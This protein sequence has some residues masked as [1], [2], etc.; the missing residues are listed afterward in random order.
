MTK[1]GFACS[2]PKEIAPLYVVEK[3]DK[4]GKR[5]D[6]DD[7]DAPKEDAEEEFHDVDSP[8]SAKEG[9]DGKKAV[10]RGPRSQL[11]RLEADGSEHVSGK[12]SCVLSAGGGIE[13]VKG[14][15][16]GTQVDFQQFVLKLMEDP[17]TSPRPLWSKETKQVAL[18]VN[19]LPYATEGRVANSKG[20]NMQWNLLGQLRGHVGNLKRKK[21]PETNDWEDAPLEEQNQ[22][23]LKLAGSYGW[24]GFA[25][26]R[27]MIYPKLNVAFIMMRN[28]F[29]F[30]NMG[31]VTS[32]D[33]AALQLGDS[34]DGSKISKQQAM[35]ATWQNRNSKGGGRG[36]RRS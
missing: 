13:L 23:A 8:K 26:T 27:F 28:C 32:F 20:K 25:G 16:I 4:D 30:R 12:A 10:G 19:H 14:G 31:M 33:R 2:D 35:D 15:L 6:E 18:E 1:T 7:D 36:G 5:I 11:R 24:G 17:A 9:A 29:A 21:N 34:G 22:I 3:L